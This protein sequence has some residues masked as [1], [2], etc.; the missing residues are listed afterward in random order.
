MQAVE[1]EAP[2]ENGVVYIPKEYNDLQN[3]KNAKFI[4]MYE[5]KYNKYEKEILSDIKN[6]PEAIKEEGYKTNKFI[7]INDL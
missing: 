5:D 4:I 6:L 7:E 1:F 3:K 2:I